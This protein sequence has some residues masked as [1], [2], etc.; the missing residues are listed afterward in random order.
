[1]HK[2]QHW[3]RAAHLLDL[4]CIVLPGEAVLRAALHNVGAL[5]AGEL[6]LHLQCQ[7]MCSTQPAASADNSRPLLSAAPAEYD[8]L[9]VLCASQLHIITSS[10][11]LKPSDS[12]MLVVPLWVFSSSPV[13][14]GAEAAA[15]CTVLCS[16]RAKGVARRAEDAGRCA[17]CANVRPAN[18]E[19]LRSIKVKMLAPRASLHHKVAI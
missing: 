3:C 16:W 19:D 12:E 7:V 10:K 17:C 9:Q 15:A 1:M 2:Q 11:G 4:R 6:G 8:S 5:D 14:V 18:I 13:A